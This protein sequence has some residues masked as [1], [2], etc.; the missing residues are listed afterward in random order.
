MDT[1]EIDLTEISVSPSNTRKDMMAGTEDTGLSDLVASIREH[2]LINPVIVMDRDGG[3]YDLIAGQRRFRACQQLG[4]DTIAAVVRNDL[5]PTDATV[6][7][8]VENV[9][10]ADMN[11]MDKAHA[12]KAILDRFG[13]YQTVARRAAV[14][15]PTVRRYLSFLDLHPSI[16]AKVSTFEGPAGVGTLEQVARRFDPEDQQD[17]LDQVKGFNQRVQKSI[18]HESRGDP[19]KIKPLTD[20]AHEG[21]FDVRMCPDGLC[22]AMSDGMKHRLREQLSEQLAR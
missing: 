10:R 12:Y 4:L 21:V 3:G 14:S 20:L 17:V 9:H 15:V 8:L 22:F 16:Q 18:I 19:E 13:D 5:D 2:G 1:V 6:L 11:P 7:S